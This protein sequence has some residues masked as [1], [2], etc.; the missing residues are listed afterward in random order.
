MDKPTKAP[1]SFHDL[2]TPIS[3]YDI[4]SPKLAQSLGDLE[5]ATHLNPHSSK[6]TNSPVGEIKSCKLFGSRVVDEYFSDELSRLAGC[7]V[8]QSWLAMQNGSVHARFDRSR[9]C[10]S[11]RPTL[12]HPHTPREEANNKTGPSSKSPKKRQHESPDRS[13][14]SNA[15]ELRDRWLKNSD[16][17]V[18]ALQQRFLSSDSF[19]ARVKEY[20]PSANLCLLFTDAAHSILTASFLRRLSDPADIGFSPNSMR[21]GEGELRS[22]S[23]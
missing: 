9:S 7:E 15:G 21:S 19:R 4:P 5:Q 16:I 6:Q 18:S 10:S 14:S 1:T 17:S 12:L 22:R 11:I 23:V 2:E 20:Q 3:S 8:G 13:L